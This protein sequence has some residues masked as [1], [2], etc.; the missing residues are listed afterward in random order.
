MDPCE[1]GSLVDA[2]LSTPAGSSRIDAAMHGVLHGS[3]VDQPLYGN[4]SARV[5]FFVASES[6]FRDPG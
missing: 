2:L 5:T 3:A 1:K 6:R 4:A